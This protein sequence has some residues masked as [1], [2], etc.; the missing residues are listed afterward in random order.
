MV[1]TRALQENALSCFSCQ[2]HPKLQ[3]TKLLSEQFGAAEKLEE[4][5]CLKSWWT[6]QMFC[7]LPG[8]CPVRLTPPAEFFMWFLGMLGWRLRL[9][10]WFRGI[11]RVEVNFFTFIWLCFALKDPVLCHLQASLAVPKATLK[12]PGCLKWLTLLLSITSSPQRAV[13]WI[14]STEKW[15]KSL[16][17]VP[18]AGIFVLS[19]LLHPPCLP[20]HCFLSLFSSKKK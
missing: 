19:I 5:T 20:D 10:L 3:W 7:F 15:L 12:V 16:L 8:G 14:L 2:H 17:N 1:V 4:C 13:K 11:C 18:L 6:E 9:K